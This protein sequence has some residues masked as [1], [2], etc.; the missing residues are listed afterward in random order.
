VTSAVSGTKRIVVAVLVVLAWVSGCAGQPVQPATRPSTSAASAGSEA[1]TRS[2]AP[3]A[4]AVG[5]YGSYRT[6]ERQVTFAEPAHTGPADR[7]LGQPDALKTM[8][9]DGNVT[10]TA[11]LVGG[12]QPPP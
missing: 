10:G 8:T 11:A 1:R 5:G 7:Y 9:R 3:T 6:A 12:G 2:A 4:A